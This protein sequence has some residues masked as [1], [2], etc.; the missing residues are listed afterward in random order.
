MINLR[1]VIE[2]YF[3]NILH[4]QTA[5]AYISYAYFAAKGGKLMDGLMQ[6]VRYGLRVL[7]KNR[8]YTFVAV[9]TLLLGIGASTAIFSVVYGVLLRPLPYQNPEQIVRIWETD[10]KGRRMNFSDPNFEDLRSQVHSLQGIAQMRSGET[11][12]LVGDAPERV[13]VAQVSADFFSVMGVQPV[14]G[15]LFG[16]EEQRSGT[17]PTAVVSHSY[18]Q[19]RLHETQDLSSVKFTISDSPAVI[20]GVLPPGFRFP[21]DSDVWTPRELGVRLPSRTAHNWPVIARIR[22][23][24]S[25]DQARADASTVARRISQENGLDEKGMADVMLLPLSDALTSDVKPA[26]LVLLGVAGLLLLVACANVMN[27]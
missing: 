25:L 26:L 5:G 18:W 22:D 21:Q 14:L 10:P 3:R 11:T 20:I 13:R 16:T 1:I 8:I 9:L 2:F 24:A 4:V 17:T 12:V 15:R 23:G 27:L 19:R 7:W 6:D